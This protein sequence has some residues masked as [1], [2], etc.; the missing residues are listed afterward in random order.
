MKAI[1]FVLLIAVLVGCKKENNVVKPDAT[2]DYVNLH[3]TVLQTVPIVLDLNKDGRQ[4]LLFYIESVS[5]T[6]NDYG[7]F[8]VVPQ[9][10]TN[11]LTQGITPKV[12]N[13]NDSIRSVSNAGYSWSEDP[14]IL[15]TRYFPVDLAN[16]YWEG[17]WK[18][19]QNKYL[20]VQ[21]T[22]DSKTYNAWVRISAVNDKSR[23]IIHDAGISKS[24][25][26]SIAAGAME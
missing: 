24:P 15:A 17:A 21:L 7:E 5:A 10:E 19:T 1:V 12:V 8:R 16:S 11:I 23:I 3:D 14:A 25:G 13:K 18:N 4:D 6:P 20:G 9:I 22:K 26:T 2:V